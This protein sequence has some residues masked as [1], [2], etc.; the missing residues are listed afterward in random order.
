MFVALFAHPC[1]VLGHLLGH[2]IYSLSLPIDEADSVFR[3]DGDLPVVQETNPVGEGYHGR[4]VAAYHGLPGTVGH[5]YPAGVSQAERDELVSWLSQPGSDYCL[6]ALEPG[7]HVDEGLLEAEPPRQSLFYDVGDHLAVRLRREG[8]PPRD[9]LLL[10]L[11]V[12]LH[13]AVV[14]NH[15][16]GRGSRYAGER[17]RRWVYR[18]WPTGCGRFP[19]GPLGSRRR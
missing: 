1:R 5:H 10:E 4:E 17:W 19:D 2:L 9:E 6:G 7:V 12:V 18:G 8:M 11:E 16:P 3:Y 13:D 15:G 14:D